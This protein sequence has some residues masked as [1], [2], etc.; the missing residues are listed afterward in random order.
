MA[1]GRTVLL[2]DKLLRGT[3]RF[4]RTAP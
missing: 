4:V 3:P 2:G 1:V